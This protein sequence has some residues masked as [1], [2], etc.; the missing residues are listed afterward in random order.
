M[1]DDATALDDLRQ[2]AK[3]YAKIDEQLGKD[4]AYI[5]L[6]IPMSYR[7]HG[8]KVTGYT[9]SPATSMYVDLGAIGVAK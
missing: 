1:I 2:Q 8:S 3:A 6:D 7:L 9:N 5:P 4:I